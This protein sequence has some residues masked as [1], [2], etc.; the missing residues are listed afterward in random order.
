MP[1]TKDALLHFHKSHFTSQPLPPVLHP[2]LGFTFPGLLGE[3]QDDS[4]DDDYLGY[5]EDGV[6]RILTDE[7]V[8]IFRHTEVQELFKKMARNAELAAEA[9][10]PDERNPMEQGASG[11]RKTGK[12]Q[13]TKSGVIDRDIQDTLNED[14]RGKHPNLPESRRRPTSPTQYGTS[15][16][17]EEEGCIDVS[18]M[19]AA[20]TAGV[21]SQAPKLVSNEAILDSALG[22]E[23]GAT[24][25]GKI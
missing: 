20:P 14:L 9:T 1:F 7:Q 4:P 15:L 17:Y 19:H 2:T 22:W 5:Y 21:R 24:S 11:V 18:D 25:N 8:A 13:K 16:E 6:K 12:G 3:L 23:K 10:T